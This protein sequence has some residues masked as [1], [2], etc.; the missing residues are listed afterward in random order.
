MRDAVSAC[1]AREAFRE[2]CYRLRFSV[3]PLRDISGDQIGHAN[4]MTIHH[5]PTLP[6][7]EKQDQNYNKRQYQAGRDDSRTTMFVTRIPIVELDDDRN[8]IA[9]GVQPCVR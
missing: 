7:C 3:R 5:F 9:A 1:L 4:A 6:A 2:P 8:D